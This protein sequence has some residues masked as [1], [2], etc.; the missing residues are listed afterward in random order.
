MKSLIH[1]AIDLPA[2]IPR[3]EAPSKDNI[4]PRFLDFQTGI[5]LVLNAAII[6]AAAIMVILIAL[7]GLQYMAANGNEEG[8]TKARHLILGSI[9]GFALILGTW[10]IMQFVFGFI[11]YSFG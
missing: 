6:I 7:G 11:G 3:I 1:L 10:A 2:S 5:P 9:V 8:T 4:D